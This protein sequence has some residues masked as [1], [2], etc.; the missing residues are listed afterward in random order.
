MGLEF[1]YA[2]TGY[3]ALGVTLTAAVAR[4]DAQ[5]SDARLGDARPSEEAVSWVP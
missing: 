2:H 1:E 3:G 5:R 4:G